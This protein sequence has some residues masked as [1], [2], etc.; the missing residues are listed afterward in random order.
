MHFHEKR[1]QQQSQIS[2]SKKLKPKINIAISPGR[3]DP[4]PS[5]I[6]IHAQHFQR[7]PQNLLR[8]PQSS[9]VNL[10]P[11]PSHYQMNKPLQ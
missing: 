4:S 6:N 1:C 3:A 9:R 8:S 5:N 2:Q 11:S 7:K 10:R